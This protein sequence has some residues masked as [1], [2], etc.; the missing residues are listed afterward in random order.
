MRVTPEAINAM[1]D[2][3]WPGARA[4]CLDVSGE[5]ARGRLTPQPSD[6]RPGGFL[7]GPAQ[8]AI[9]D[10][11]LWFAVL[12]AIGNID[13]TVLTSELSIR[14]LRPAA[15]TTLSAEARIDRV[16]KRSAVGTIKV[17]VDDVS[18]RPTAVAQG[19]YALRKV[20]ASSGH[21]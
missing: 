12:G 5:S 14:Y 15:G 20:W 1:L 17:W 4:V 3:L 2:E 21:P 11:T 19:S 13:P 8:F 10:A 7:S 9:A 6:V 16:G 18:E